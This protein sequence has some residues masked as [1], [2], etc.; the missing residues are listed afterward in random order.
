MT[1]RTAGRARPA[2]GAAAGKAARRRGGAAF[3][4]I[5]GLS[6]SG[7]SAAVKALEDQGAYCVDNLPVALLPRMLE[8]AGGSRVDL[9][10]VVLGMDI[11]ER[12]FVREFPR[13]FRAA[14]A[15]GI[16]IRLLFFEASESVLVR[17]Y[18]ETRRV[19]PLG[20]GLPLVEAIRAERQ[21][22]EPLRGLADEVID[23]SQM[24]V[25][26]LRERMLGIARER[27]PPRELVVTV[28]SFGFKYGVPADADLVFDVRFLANP[29]FEEGLRPL[30]GLDDPVREFVLALP[31]AGAFLGALQSFLAFLVPLYRVDGRAYLTIAFGC[32]GGRHRS[33]VIAREVADALV[34]LGFRVAVRNRDIQGE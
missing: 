19:H 12:R 30:S 27:R 23:T 13:V 29:F 4:V 28:L 31:E 25:R 18:S 7:K 34:G 3:L 16:P 10:L 6:G 20:G 26:D 22:L 21:E 9:G 14:R 5:T 1:G 15:R 8:L 11:R 2:R 33:P 17:R 24:R 32:T